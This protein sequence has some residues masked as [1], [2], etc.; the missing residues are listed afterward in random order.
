MGVL[1]IF[2]FDLTCVAKVSK[3]VLESLYLDSQNFSYLNLDYD[4]CDGI[5]CFLLIILVLAAWPSLGPG[6]GNLVRRFIAD[7]CRHLYQNA[8]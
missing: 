2:R 5:A 4:L 3:N 6:L 1:G 8:V 7:F